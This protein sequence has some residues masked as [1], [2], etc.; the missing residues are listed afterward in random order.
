MESSPS[1]KGMEKLVKFSCLLKLQDP[2]WLLHPLGGD[3]VRDP[4]GR[5]QVGALLLAE[6]GQ[7]LDKEDACLGCAW[8]AGPF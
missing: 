5:E 1:L 3:H 4:V 7:I 2:M 6:V 8:G